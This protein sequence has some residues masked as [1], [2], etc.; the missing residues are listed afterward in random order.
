MFLVF[1]QIHY[2]NTAIDWFSL[3]YEHTFLMKNIRCITNSEYK[4]FI[5]YQGNNAFTAFDFGY[6]INE[7]NI[8]A[9]MN[10][11][12]SD[13]HKMIT[14]FIKIYGCKSGF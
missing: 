2:L 8:M 1:H 6:K 14:N 12:L 9:K 5:I 7:S 3:K 4:F 11:T 13:K 10:Y